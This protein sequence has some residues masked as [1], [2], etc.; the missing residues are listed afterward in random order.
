MSIIVQKFGGTSVANAERIRAAAQR[1]VDAKRKGHQVVMVISARG[2]KTDELIELA[3][4]ISANP[5]AREMD[6]LL[7]T[8]EQE[9]VALVAMAIQELG[10]PAVSLTGMGRVRKYFNIFLAANSLATSILGISPCGISISSEILLSFS[11]NSSTSR[12]KG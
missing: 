4:E 6:M 9:A 10:E 5:P 1:A 2:Q 11:C 8:G 12:L 7:A 3:N